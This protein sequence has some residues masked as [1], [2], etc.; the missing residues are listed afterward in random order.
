[1]CALAMTDAT[2]TRSGPDEEKLEEEFLLQQPLRGSN[3]LLLW[4]LIEAVILTILALLPAIL[5]RQMS[6]YEEYDITQNKGHTGLNSIMEFWRYTVFIVAAYWIFVLIL[7]GINVVPV[8]AVRLTEGLS[9]KTSIYWRR[10]MYLMRSC[11][12]S[13][14]ISLLM[15]GI[16]VLSG[17]MIFPSSLIDTSA[18]SLKTQFTLTSDNITG[19]IL[20][21]LCI[22]LF[23]FAALHGLTQYSIEYLGYHHH[24]E[25]FSKRVNEVNFAF[26]AVDRLYQ[27]LSRGM[28]PPPKLSTMASLKKRKRQR[29]KQQ[30]MAGRQSSLVEGD[31][32]LST[33]PKAEALALKL[34]DIMCPP[35]HD[36][37]TIDD[38]RP[39]YDEGELLRSFAVFDRHHIGTVTRE[40]FTEAIV[41]LHEERNNL[42][43]SMVCNR[44]VV[45]KL[46]RT[47]TAA[48]LILSM[49]TGIVLF[50]L[51]TTTLVVLFGVLYL[52]FNFMIQDGLTSLYD[53]VQFLFVGHAYDVGD[54]VI[55]KG[56]SLLVDRID[57]YTS[58]FRRW[59]GTLVFISNNVLAIT[60]IYNVK[61]SG[62]NS[63]LI[64]LTIRTQV[65]IEKIWLFRDRMLAFVRKHGEEFTGSLDIASID[66]V[67]SNETKVALLV[68]YRGNFQ[69]M[70]SKSARRSLIDK[71]IG[72]VRTEMSI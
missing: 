9:G 10:Q 38:F 33:P 40:H 59:D 27:A 64:D 6:G 13:L 30:K 17:I 4:P 41:R 3:G 65:P 56:E 7:I 26:M 21:R 70:A 69:D 36:H 60:T 63:E 46:G 15:L 62:N 19:F 39:Y 71:E 14:A 61:R 50:K 58:H 42:E 37:L 32:D 24:R 66:V 47:L 16:V 49:L 12:Y 51:E 43:Q 31:V 1:M 54:R 20:E 5:A 44:R 25:A 55:I 28:E 2:T 18:T 34:F 67:D 48:S 23:I 68:E 52:G 57:L 11:R 53:C 8:I 35:N 45:T 29:Q 72:R 22:F